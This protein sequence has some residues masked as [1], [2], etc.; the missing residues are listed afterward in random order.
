M[1][2]LLQ[3]TY[4]HGEIRGIVD[5]F[6]EDQKQ[7]IEADAEVFC[8]DETVISQIID[9]IDGGKYIF[10]EIVY[11]FKIW[12]AMSTNFGKTNR[13]YCKPGRA[14]PHKFPR[15]EKHHSQRIEQKEDFC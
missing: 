6:L 5:C 7:Q 15:E 10:Y 1:I 14:Q 3:E 8:T 13:I 2:H 12:D 9:L 11:G 4:V